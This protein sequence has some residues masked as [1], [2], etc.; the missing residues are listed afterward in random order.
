M[1]H[2]VPDLGDRLA[3]GRGV[4]A[5][6]V[7]LV[8][9]RQMWCS[10]R[11]A[12]AA[13]PDLDRVGLGAVLLTLQRP[14]AGQGDEQDCQGDYRQGDRGD[15]RPNGGDQR[16]GPALSRQAGDYSQIR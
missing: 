8:M 2:D 7:K 11:V 15:A 14:Q 13:L 9:Y 3:S 12:D 1:L 16:A 10:D 4:G 6:Q 5:A